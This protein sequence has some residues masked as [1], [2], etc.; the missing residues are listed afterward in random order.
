VTHELPP[1]GRDRARRGPLPRLHVVT[2]DATLGLPRWEA[3]AMG[4]LS[5]GGSDICLHLRGPRTGGAVLHGLASRL[6]PVAGRAGAVLV[7]NDRVDLALA[8]PL[9]GVHLGRRSL[10]VGV[11]RELLGPERWLGASAGSGEEAAWAWREGAD[12][13]FVGT[14]FATA[15]HPE[16]TEL[17]LEGLAATLRGHQGVT[18]IAI[19]GIGPSAVQSVLAAGAYGVAVVGGVWAQP[20]PGAAL[21]RY[22]EAI[23]GGTVTDER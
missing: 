1:G 22:L 15:T 2:D 8:V 3:L 9:H 23:H 6:L 5:V 18:A 20:D 21:R 4:V 11:V 16:A 10:P 12:Y 13:A 14:T 17:G 7:V 19:G